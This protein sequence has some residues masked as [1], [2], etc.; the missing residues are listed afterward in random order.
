MDAQ[1]RQRAGTFGSVA[2]QQAGHRPGYPDEA[3][4]WLVGEIP[5]RI[6][7]LGAD[8]G[9][10]TVALS[11]LGHEV[12]A[13]DPSAAVL[14]VLPAAATSVTRV[15][16]RAED[17]PL[18]SSS[19]DIVV[20]DQAFHWLDSDQALPEIARVLRPGGEVALVSNDGDRMVPWVRRLFELVDVPSHHEL[21]GEPFDDTDTFVLTGTRRFRHWQTFRREALTGFISSM[22]AGSTLAPPER[23]NLLTRAEALYDSYGR[24]PDGLRIPWVTYCYRARVAGLTSRG[25]PSV[26]ASPTDDGL[27]IDFD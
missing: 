4:A 13:T 21:G 25:T 2:A 22:S 7:E 20:T 10:L 17:I 3:V 26:A 9:G 12:I 23:A 11:L 14:A 5:R 19:V 6:L 1:R 15:Q 18:S 8:R 16:S 24:G 27:L